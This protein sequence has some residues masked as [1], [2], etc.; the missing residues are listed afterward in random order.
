M[1]DTRAKAIRQQFS[2]NGRP[3]LLADVA[4]FLNAELPESD[5]YITLILG[6]A[7]ESKNSSAA[8]EESRHNRDRP[9]YEAPD[10]VS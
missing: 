1:S 9:H 2:S 5:V 8:Y 7:P 10:A 6:L 3:E 4:R